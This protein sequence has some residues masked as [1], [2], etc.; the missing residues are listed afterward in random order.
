MAPVSC[1]V[2]Y[3][4][5]ANLT[6]AIVMAAA[7]HLVHF[8]QHRMFGWI[9]HCVVLVLAIAAAASVS[10]APEMA[11]VELLTCTAL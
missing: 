9:H 1:T 10:V 2:H 3:Q 7:T 6:S 5:D 11:I 8:P 4:V